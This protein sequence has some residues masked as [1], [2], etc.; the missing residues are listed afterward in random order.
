MAFVG[1]TGCGKSTSINL[2]QRLYDVD[3]GTVTI[4]GFDISRYDVHHLRR[5]IGIVS[6]DNV[7]FSCSIKENI[8]YGMGQ[9]HLRAPTDKEIWE[10]C[11]KA[12]A[13]EFINSF[14]NKL[15]LRSVS[16]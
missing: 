13:T 11:D 5:H 1:K 8:T 6:Q 10:I 7:L 14:P 9:G 2:L 16:I 15:Y 3:T 12:N 4:D